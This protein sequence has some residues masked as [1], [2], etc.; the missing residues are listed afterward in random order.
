MTKSALPV[1][2]TGA[3]IAREPRPFLYLE[4]TR[5]TGDAAADPIGLQRLETAAGDAVAPL[6]RSLVNFTI[7]TQNRSALARGRAQP[8]QLSVLNRRRRAAR[9]WILAIL[10]GK[11]DAATRHAVAHTWLPT[12]VG[13]GPDTSAARPHAQRLIE[14]VRGAITLHLFDAP[15][16]NLLHSARALHVLESTLAVHLGAVVFEAAAASRR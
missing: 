5:A 12:L 15:A 16:D 14:F 1:L 9:S 6:V 3:S 13:T 8:I 7:A 2:D 10:A 11:T 4:A